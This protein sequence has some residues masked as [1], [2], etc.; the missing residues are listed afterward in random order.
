LRNAISGRPIEWAQHQ[1]QSG[2]QDNWYRYRASQFDPA[3]CHSP[4]LACQAFGGTLGTHTDR[5]LA[6]G[7]ER[8]LAGRRL[9]AG[10]LSLSLCACHRESLLSCSIAV[11][12]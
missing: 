8:R 10:F 9:I 6:S 7:A 12:R 5:R 4:A 2:D 11:A 1:Q 3:H